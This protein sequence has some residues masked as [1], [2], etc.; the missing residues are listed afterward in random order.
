MERLF[1][2]DGTEFDGYALQSDELFLYMFGTDLQ[3]VFDALIDP[4]K[5]EHITY[6]MVNGEQI[7]YTGYTKLVAVREE[8]STLTTAIMRRG[9]VNNV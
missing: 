9:V 1:L 5:T 4:D 2:N 8:S 6:V 3:T 7:V